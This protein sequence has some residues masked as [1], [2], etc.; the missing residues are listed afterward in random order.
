MDIYKK[1]EREKALINAANLMRQQT[2]NEAVRSKLDN[3]MR[4]GRRNLEFFEEKLRDLQMRRLGQGVENVNLSSGSRPRSADYRG[5][6]GGPPPPPP[7]DASGWGGGGTY[8]QGQFSQI[9]QHGD[10]MPSQGPFPGQAPN[11]GIPKPRPNFTK[12]GTHPLWI[13][14][15]TIYPLTYRLQI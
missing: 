2:N 7:K 3:Q 10:M 5:D 6:Q 11:S 15:T 14:R 9:G 4:D 1:I 12:L 13:S 8:S